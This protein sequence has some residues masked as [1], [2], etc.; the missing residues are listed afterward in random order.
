VIRTIQ[1]NMA[2]RHHLRDLPIDV[3]A[4]NPGAVGVDYVGNNNASIEN[5]VLRAGPDSGA[6][7]LDM[8][9]YGPGPLLVTDLTVEGFATGIGVAHREYAPTPQRVTLTGQRE[10]GIAN[11]GNSLSMV[12]V[13]SRNAVPAVVSRGGTASVALLD[14]WLE[15][16]GGAGT[17]AIVS[18]AAV[19]L[20]NVTAPG[21]ASVLEQD[22]ERL[23]GTEVTEHHAGTTGHAPFAAAA[24][25]LGLPVVEAPTAP[26]VPA[27]DWALFRPRGY[28]EDK[29]QVQG[30]FDSGVAFPFETYFLHNEIDVPC[31]VRRVTGFG[32][33]I[34]GTD[35]VDLTLR[36]AQDCDT[37]LVVEDFGYGAHV[38]HEGA[39]TVVLRHGGF[40]YRS[41]A[42]AG[43]L[44]LENVCCFPLTGQPGQDVWAR[45][46]DIEFRPLQIDNAGGN[47]WSSDTRPR[48][49]ACSPTPSTAAAPRSSVA[50]RTRSRRTTGTPRPRRSGAV[51]SRQSIWISGSNYAPPGLYRTY[52]EETRDGRTVPVAA[53]DAP[54]WRLF[55]GAADG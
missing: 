17:A 11:D 31:S 8:R 41:T 28:N 48:A 26:E 43:D 32:A 33:A 47:L 42:G 40:G 24:R 38:V 9:R 19:L 15:G 7:G 45:Q 5:V 55:S 37:P 35:G 4:G 36:V 18:E 34:N 54:G 46:L 3:G 12:Q 49:A 13:L 52:V 21:Y 2:F 51:N 29:G 39:R 1:G 25:T 20:R 30:L 44:F 23:P 10:V 27:A 6:V 22:G 14:R 53:E 16:T 50:W